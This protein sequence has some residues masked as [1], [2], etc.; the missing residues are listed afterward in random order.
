MKWT[1]KCYPQGPS[2]YDIG[3]LT[4]DGIYSSLK[5]LLVLEDEDLDPSLSLSHAMYWASWQLSSAA[6]GRGLP[7]SPPSWYHSLS[8]SRAPSQDQPDIMIFDDTPEVY[9]TPPT[10]I[11]GTERTPSIQSISEP[12]TSELSFALLPGPSPGSS[13]SYG[14]PQHLPHPNEQIMLAVSQA[15]VSPLYD[16]APEDSASLARCASAEAAC[17]QHYVHPT[18]SAH[19]TP[20]VHF[21]A[22]M[23]TSQTILPESC[24]EPDFPAL[25]A[26]PMSCST[27]F[28]ADCALI[29]EFEQYYG[30]GVTTPS[31]DTKEQPQ[32]Y[33]LLEA[34]V[35]DDSWE[36]ICGGVSSSPMYPSRGLSPIDM[37]VYQLRSTREGD[38][39]ADNFYDTCLFSNEFSV[40]DAQSL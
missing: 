20:Q 1:T 5:N 34:G 29:E 8:T 35:I 4:P 22:S 26:T 15:H 40:A 19:S 7:S 39:T 23:Q 9:A 36:S 38:E 17:A 24:D 10:P 32:S 12:Y 28:S 18:I 2:E 33:D 14:T 16:A 31:L 3:V 13:R 30:S 6:T 11:I 37:G 27:S 25:S 21:I